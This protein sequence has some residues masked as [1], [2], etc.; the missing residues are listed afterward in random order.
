MMAVAM[1][2]A[3]LLDSLAQSL[4][5]AL[6]ATSEATR[7]DCPKDGVSL[8]DLKNELLLSYLQNLVFLILLKL[9]HAKQL[10]AGEA[11]GERQISDG[12]VKKLVELRLYLEKGVRPLEDKLAHTISTVLR[13]AADSERTTQAKEAP[14]SAHGLKKKRVADGVD[15]SSDS[16]LDSENGD[17]AQDRSSDDSEVE[18]S[19]A[20]NLRA[21]VRNTAATRGMA[22]AAG[23]EKTGVYRPPKITPT[24][25]PTTDRRERAERR[26][27]KSATMDDF[28]AA[29]LSTAPLA[30]PS[31]GTTIISGGRK[32]KT[33][34]ERKEEAERQEY[35][36]MNFI[37]LPKES[38]KER[39]RKAKMEGRSG[40]VNFGGEEWRE[41]GAG[42]DRIERLTKARH[43]GK[44]TRALLDKSRK[45]GRETV[46]GP[47]GSGAPEIGERF[48][49][50]LKVMEG[51][52]MDRGKG[53]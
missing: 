19:N 7:V 43:S 22:A 13:A 20:P 36:E 31:I 51:G 18:I 15:S 21:F 47:R 53:R 34:T 48:K 27:N 37:R 10:R 11:A 30:E 50:K 39:A 23:P 32:V 12:V 5:S 8:L 28:I 26:P 9:R 2:L 35:E 16:G 46:D 41:L 38:K 25:M 45:R 6:E 1:S 29:E 44:G 33:D 3:G 49:K 14:K 40:R 4:S 52:R 42:A 24:V 17:N